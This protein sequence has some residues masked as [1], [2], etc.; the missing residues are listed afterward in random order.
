MALMKSLDP[1]HTGAPVTYWR[2]VHRQDFFD[3]KRIEIA[4]AGYVS[5]VARRAGCNPLGTPRCY[6]LMLADFP[7]GTDWHAITTAMLYSALKAKL[8]KA[9]SEA[10]DGN[11]RRLPEFNGAPVDTCLAGAGDA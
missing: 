10:R 7:P 8:A 5:E 6:A 4:L 2:I 11:P 9:A 3:A 1:D